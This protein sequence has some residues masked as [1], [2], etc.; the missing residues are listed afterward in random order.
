MVKTRPYCI[1]QSS[2]FAH[3]GKKSRAHPATQNRRQY[4][5][6]KPV[7]ISPSITQKTQYKMCL[8]FLFGMQKY[9]RIFLLFG[10]FNFA[11]LTRGHVSEIGICKLK[12]IF[13]IYSTCNGYQNIFGKIVLTS[14]INKVIP[15]YPT[16]SC[17]GSCYVAS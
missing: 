14:V 5:L 10:K 2:P 13:S 6:C 3:L 17:F 1:C 4:C 7:F 16:N 15:F 12:H 8:F 9:L 11:L